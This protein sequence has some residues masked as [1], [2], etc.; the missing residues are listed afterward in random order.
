MEKCLAESEAVKRWAVEA[1][2]M[3]QIKNG[4]NARAHLPLAAACQT[5]IQLQTDRRHG[6]T[7]SCIR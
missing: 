1:S 4:L 5:T 6:H 7:R 2:W 3:G